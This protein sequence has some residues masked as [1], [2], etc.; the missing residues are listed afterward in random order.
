MRKERRRGSSGD[1]T[2]RFRRKSARGGPTK[3]Y[4]GNRACIRARCEK[5]RCEFANHFLAEDAALLRGSPI[6]RPDGIREPFRAL[7][8]Q[9]PRAAAALFLDEDA[10]AWLRLRRTEITA[11]C[12]EVCSMCARERGA[13]RRIRQ[14][15]TDAARNFLRAVRGSHVRRYLLLFLLCVGA[16]D[17][18][19][20]IDSYRL[21]R[22]PDDA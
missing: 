2:S 11:I 6:R 15:W 12:A 5:A 14:R 16:R 4:S 20:C 19:L 18:K 10:R 21:A 7:L 9:V 17:R 13:V 22:F 1:P 8:E 3:R